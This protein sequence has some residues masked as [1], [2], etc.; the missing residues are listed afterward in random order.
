MAEAALTP[1]ANPDDPGAG[2]PTPGRGPESGPRDSVLGNL[3]RVVERRDMIRFLVDSNLRA[4]HRD[5]VLGNLWNLLDPLLFLAVYF[6]VFG[7]GFRQVGSDPMVF[8]VYLSIGVIVYRYLDGVVS[9]S[10]VCIR[11]HRGLVNEVAFPRAV[12]PISVCISRLYDFLWALVVVA[13]AVLLLRIEVTP[14]LLW[15]PVAVGL[16]TMLA[17]GLGLVVAHSGAFFADTSNILSFVMRLLFFASPIVYLARSE[18]GH[19]GIVPE[20]WLDLYGLNPLAGLMDLYRDALLWGRAPEPATLLYVSGVALAVLLFGF[21]LFSRAEGQ[22][23]KY[24]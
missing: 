15:L 11:L 4:G 14:H 1:S 21:A 18:P 19:P 5:K 8:A 22:Y 9:Q 23:A 20:R 24:L 16:H 3:L 12:L 7:I 2:G 17:L 13:A 10:A 6:L